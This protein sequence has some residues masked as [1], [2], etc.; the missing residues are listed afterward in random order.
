MSFMS[1]R[2]KIHTSKIDG[3]SIHTMLWARP[4]CLPAASVSQTKDTP[5]HDPANS[6]IS[7]L[8]NL[9]QRLRSP[10]PEAPEM[11]STSLNP[12]VPLPAVCLSR[13]PQVG[14]PS[15]TR[16]SSS[17]LQGQESPRA[18]KRPVPVLVLAEEPHPCWPSPVH[19]DLFPWEPCQTG[20]SSCRIGVGGLRAPLG[21]VSWGHHHEPPCE[22]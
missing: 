10:G 3:F 20:A 12:S 7:F 15:S 16:T 11:F 2:G 18:P 9:V 19:A 1:P 4:C 21:S 14:S 5:R 22:D 6:H 17:P 8:E 13:A